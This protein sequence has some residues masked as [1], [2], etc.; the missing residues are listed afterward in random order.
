M[1]VTDHHCFTCGQ[2]LAHGVSW[3]AIL[4]F[5]LICLSLP[6]SD[7]YAFGQ[8]SDICGPW[9][10]YCEGGGSS[11]GSSGSGGGG[12]QQPSI[13][14]GPS[15]AE[16]ERRRQSMVAN[17]KGVECASKEDYDC[18]IW[19][20]TE[21]LRLYPNNSTARTNLHKSN[22]K[23]T[24]KLGLK[25]YEQG[26]W[27]RAL[28]YFS[29]ARRYYKYDFIEKNIRAAKAEIKREIEAAAEA[30]AIA[31]TEEA[32]R[33]VDR[34]LD[35]LSAQVTK[36]DR[37]QEG[38]T[39]IKDMPFTMPVKPRLGPGERGNTDAGAQLRSAEKSGRWAKEAAQDG[40]DELAPDKAKGRSGIGFDTPGYKSEGI[41]VPDDLGANPWKEPVVSES[42]RTPAIRNI[43]L[44]RDKAKQ[45]RLILEK[46]L[47]ELQSVPD[48]QR[49]TDLVMQ[50]METKQAISN[51]SN[52]EIFYNFS[53]G[54]ELKKDDAGR[55]G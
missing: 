47:E 11:G 51:A 16:L 17:D 55:G 19:Y 36:L 44:K 53:I 13:P 3:Y 30:K 42:Q 14:A 20:Y 10:N 12:Y 37:P 49:T 35:D 6:G 21:A 7:A 26:D 43:E 28:E 32:S 40:T 5:L 46:K 9:N 24:N 8:K 2:Q 39:W 50:V 1:P 4:S 22:A 45:Q 29:K 27:T 18:S 23:Q 31:L 34:I 52:Q 48:N 54:Q 25:Y 41:T 38:V 15:P 33:E